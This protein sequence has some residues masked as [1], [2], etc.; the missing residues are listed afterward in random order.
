[1]SGEAAQRQ[2]GVALQPVFGRPVTRLVDDV[3]RAADLLRP[4]YD[5]TAAIDGYVSLEV[6]P[7]WASDTEATVTE[8]MRLWSRVNRPNLMVKVPGTEPGL[9]AIRQ[10]IAEGINVNVTLLSRP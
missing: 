4:I 2:I 5:E 7:H 8:A 6:S 10:L 1:M 3:Q 9:L